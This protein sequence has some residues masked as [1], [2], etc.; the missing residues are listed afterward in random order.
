MD[1]CLCRREGRRLKT[2]PEVKRTV[3]SH[4]SSLTFTNIWRLIMKAEERRA[5]MKACNSLINNRTRC[6]RLIGCGLTSL[7][8]VKVPST[9]KR[10][11]IFR[12]DFS[13]SS[14]LLVGLIKS[15]SGCKC[16]DLNCFF[17]FA[18]TAT[19]SSA[20]QFCSIS[21]AQWVRSVPL[22]SMVQTQWAKRV[23]FLL[24]HCNSPG[25]QSQPEWGP[26]RPQM[27]GLITFS[28]Q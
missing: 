12:F 19:F 27:G 20:L 13:I 3:C 5:F 17:S 26:W 11:R 2:V 24:Q 21:S 9:S 8:G 1:W 23:G 22:Q 7:G 10:Q 14:S 18:L 4:I 28:I 6:Y 25:S 16:P 15:I